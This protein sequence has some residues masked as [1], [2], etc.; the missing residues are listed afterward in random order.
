M[1]S[2]E[3]KTTPIEAFTRSFRS[4][5]NVLQYISEH[6]HVFVGDLSPEVDNK[7]LKE[8][9]AI[10]GEVSEAK[11]I[12]DSQTQKSKGYGFVSYPSKEN[13]EKAITSMNGYRLGR[14]AIRTNWATRRS[15][16]EAREKLTFEQ[17]HSH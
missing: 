1:L 9:F 14:R 15:A 12:R 11:V 4:E 2:A 17:V 3:C 6:F 8:A 10:H 5:D 16:D 13:A 7:A